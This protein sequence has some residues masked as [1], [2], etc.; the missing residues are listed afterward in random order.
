MSDL[1][2]NFRDEMRKISRKNPQSALDSTDRFILKFPKEASLWAFRSFL[3]KKLN[4]FESAISDI[5][6][7]IHISPNDPCNYWDRGRIYLEIQGY[8]QAIESFSISIDL[9]DKNNFDYYHES[10]LFFR[11]FCFCKLGKFQDAELDI[12]HVRPGYSEWVDRLRS[13]EEIIE[14]CKKGGF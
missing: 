4:Q 13:K 3:K 5:D 12:C 11:A 7:A 9:G 10:S 1:I 2:Q 6:I 8:I 14:I